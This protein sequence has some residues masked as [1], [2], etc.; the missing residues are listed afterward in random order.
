M[1]IMAAAQAVRADRHLNKYIRY[2]GMALS[3]RELVIRLVNEGRVP[4]Q[5][6][7]D[8][9]QPATRMQMFRWDNEQQRE[10]ERKRAAGGKKTEYCLSRHDGVFIE[11]SKTM[12]DFAAQLLAEKEVAHGH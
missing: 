8:K 11:V 2:N 1:C 5:V 4:E 10:H 3:K 7:V 12:H 6:E 9:V